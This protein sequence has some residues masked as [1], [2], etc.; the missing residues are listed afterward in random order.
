MCRLCIS[1]KAQII[2]HAASNAGLFGIAVFQD[3]WDFFEVIG[4][5]SADVDLP[6]V[7]FLVDAV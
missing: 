6:A 2:P 4:I 7:E 5:G 1:S 3:V